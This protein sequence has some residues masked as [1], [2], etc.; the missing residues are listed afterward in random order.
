VERRFTQ[1]AI[2]WQNDNAR[3]GNRLSET[4]PIAARITQQS[5]GPGIT[6]QPKQLTVHHLGEAGVE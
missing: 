6:Q 2:A 1:T 5:D 3:I 4:E